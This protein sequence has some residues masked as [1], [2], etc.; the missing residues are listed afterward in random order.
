MSET[1][2]QVIVVEDNPA[3]LRVVQV[4]LNNAGYSVTT[5]ENGE[6]AWNL[7]QKNDFD[8]VITDEQMPGMSGTE[9][10]RILRSD[11][12]YESLPVFLLTAR[13]LELDL[14]RLKR[15]LNINEAFAKPF[16][17]TAL[18]EVVNTCLSPTSI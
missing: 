12:K 15:E 11:S 10:C 5:A 16:S 7:I 4:V 13:G 3:L 8:L 6:Q 9:L 14:E 1:K 18:I 2:G 17:P